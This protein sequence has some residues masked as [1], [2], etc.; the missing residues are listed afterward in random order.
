[1]SNPPLEG[2]QKGDVYSFG[3][4]VHEIIFRRGP[5]F[6]GPNIQL[7]ARGN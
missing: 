4:I 6:L 3:I 7:T 2:T 5:F 1:M